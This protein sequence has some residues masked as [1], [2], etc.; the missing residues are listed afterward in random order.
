M[1]FSTTNAQLTSAPP[2]IAAAGSA[3]FF[4]WA[5]DR[6]YWRMPC[7]VIPMAMCVIGYSIVISLHGKLAEKL[8]VAYFSVV[9]ATMGIYPIQTSVASWNANNLAPESQ[10]VIGIALLNCVGN[11][12]GI[13]GSYMYLDKE[14]PEYYTGFGTSV[15]LGGTGIVVALLLEWTYKVANAR[16]AVVAEEARSK[17]TEDEL[18]DMGD[19]SPV[20]KY[21][22]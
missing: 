18:F 21:V 1:G 11:L 15:A 6:F 8:G 5:S 13:L 10:R 14:S 3:L 4:A 2:Y 19:R 20:F 22:L 16:K 12:G 9:F 7:V 17:Y